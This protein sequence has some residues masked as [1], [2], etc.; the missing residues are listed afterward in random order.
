MT[1]A[2]QTL[3]AIKAYVA[4]RPSEDIR[5][6][7][8]SVWE[9]VIQGAAGYDEQATAEADPSHTNEEAVFADGSRLWWNSALNAW[10]T[11]P[12][13]TGADENVAVLG[14]GDRLLSL[15]EGVGA[16][17]PPIDA[18]T[19]LQADHRKV[20]DLLARYQRARDRTTKQQIAEQVFTEIDQHAQLEETV[21][22]P[23]FDAQ[24]GKKGTQLVADSRLEHEAVKELILEMRHLDIADEEFEDKFEEM[25]KNVQHHI[26]QEEHE[27]F[28]EAAQI[29]A[30]Q[31]EDLLE[32]MV[33]LKHQ[34]TTPPRQ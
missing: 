1:Q 26:A 15:R 30:E 7:C 27:M 19:M 31:L 21:F 2:Q 13:E 34:L 22:Y 9:T 24:A 8:L 5:A 3:A 25:T 32:E 29:L 18:I 10:E 11:G 23:A 16:P 17:T 6:L 14:N 33:A 20:Q 4:S 28:P 12:D